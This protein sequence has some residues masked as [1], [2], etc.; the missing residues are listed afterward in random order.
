MGLERQ[1]ILILSFL[2]LGIAIMSEETT[3]VDEQIAD[4]ILYRYWIMKPWSSASTM[5][6]FVFIHIARVR[7]PP[8]PPPYQEEFCGKILLQYYFL[9]SSASFSF[10]HNEF[11][12]NVLIFRV[13]LVDRVSDLFVLGLNLPVSGLAN[14]VALY[15][16]TD[17]MSTPRVHD[18]I[19]K[20]C[21]NIFL[22]AFLILI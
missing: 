5:V 18:W 14:Q 8:E 15:E 20:I 13:I 3:L 12:L 16:V 19:C 9:F 21:L 2:M 11:G 6:E 4:E 7:P 1:I 17:S 10:S 22:Y